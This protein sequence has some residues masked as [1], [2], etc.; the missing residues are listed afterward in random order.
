MAEPQEAVAA[1]EAL[2]EVGRVEEAHW[3]VTAVL[4]ADPSNVDTLG[5]LARC[6]EAADDNAAMLDAASRATAAGPD[7]PWAHQLRGVALLRLD[8]SREALD[9]ADTA[10]R[11]APEHWFGHIL[12][13]LALANLG[14]RRAGLAAVHHAARLAPN[15]PAVHLAEARMHQVRGRTRAARRAFHRVLAL[16]PE[17]AKAMA[18]LGHAAFTGGYLVSAARH[19]GSA[20]RAAPADP[21]GAANVEKVLH[22][23]LG[24]AAMTAWS[25]GLVLMFGMFPLA[26]LV[27]AGVVAAG[28]WWLRRIWL[29]LPP[30]GR[31]LARRQ[32]RTDARSYVRLGMAVVSAALA[33]VIG[34]VAASAG[35]DAGAGYALFALTALVGTLMIGAVAVV[36]ADARA[37]RRPPATAA[38]TR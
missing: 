27:A 31:L 35:P 6:H 36:V 10:I 33:L 4:A 19:F 14:Q 30:G 20:A 2:L 16:D 34:V 17:H 38:Q 7:E 1:A 3:R 13:G 29:A 24:W 23:A 9:E 21:A 18:A 37:R 25:A 32:V 11:L 8:R 22:A 26:W 12:K 15:Q 28:S 5:T